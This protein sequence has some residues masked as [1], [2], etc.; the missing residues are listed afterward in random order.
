M[1]WWQENCCIQNV[2]AGILMAHRRAVTVTA[3]YGA[4][5][6]GSQ[7]QAPE[8]HENVSVLCKEELDAR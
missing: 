3:W 2:L 6:F 1:F 8:H 7:Q 5:T 4:R